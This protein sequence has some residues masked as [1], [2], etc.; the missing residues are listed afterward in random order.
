MCQQ[1]MNPRHPHVV[2]TIDLVPHDRGCDYGFFCDGNVA[3]P[4]GDHRDQA[5]PAYGF[6]A[7]QYDGSGS[8]L[9]FHTAHNF[10]YGS[11]LL[12][13]GPSGQYIFSVLR[14]FLEDSCHLGG[15]FPLRQNHFGRAHPQGAVVV[16]FRETQI[17]KRHMPDSFY[18]FVGRQL[19]GVYLF[20]KFANGFS[21]HAITQLSG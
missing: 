8:F 7:T 4:R 5:L 2:Q 1:P 17:F 19:S 21:V 18:R 6:V 20:E 12:F 13:A 14:K 3:G 11:K 10:L 15:S 16:D 9:I